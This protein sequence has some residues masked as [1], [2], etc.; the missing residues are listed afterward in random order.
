MT[1]DE[2]VGDDDEEEE[3]E[4]EEQSKLSAAAPDPQQTDS[5]GV[6]VS[7]CVVLFEKVCV[8]CY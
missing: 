5:T 6:C 1:L 4:E 8:Y 2:A 7:V 3:M